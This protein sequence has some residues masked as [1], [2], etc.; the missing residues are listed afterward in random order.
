MGL[1]SSKNE[2]ALLAAVGYK[3]HDPAVKL[4]TA[5]R[6]KEQVNG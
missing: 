3:V 4:D 5:P 6:S 1:G 2:A